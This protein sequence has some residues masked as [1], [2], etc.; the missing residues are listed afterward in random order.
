MKDGRRGC[1]PLEASP[2]VLLKWIGAVVLAFALLC[3]GFGYLINE[4]N[5][6]ARAEAEKQT[7]EKAA[8]KA[9]FEALTAAEHLSKASEALANDS[10][11]S[12]EEGLHHIEAILASSL[13]HKSATDLKLKLVR[14]QSLAE[15]DK[16][17]TEA[18]NGKNAI[19]NLR[20]AMNRYIQPVLKTDKNDADAITDVQWQTWGPT[21][22]SPLHPGSLPSYRGKSVKFIFELHEISKDAPAKL[23]SLQPYYFVPSATNPTRLYAGQELIVEISYELPKPQADLGAARSITDAAVPLITID[24]GSTQATAINVA[25]VRPTQG[26]N[27]FSLEG[28]TGEIKTM[29]ACAYKK[30]LIG[31]TIPTVRFRF[32]DQRS[33]MG[34]G[35]QT[36]TR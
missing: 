29:Y 24:I 20:E 5:K 18:A 33:G 16:L 3:I 14:A 1:V 11:E 15:A 27:T 23:K 34:K 36:Q 4:G 28:H 6:R 10:P 8:E 25:P 22:C 17:I 12:I 7:R 32:H 21:E 19:Y 31:S 9:R 2:F 13:Q 35:W 30:P 26:Q